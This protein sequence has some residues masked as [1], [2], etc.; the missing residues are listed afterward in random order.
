MRDF[1]KTSFRDHFLQGSFLFGSF[2]ELFKGSFRDFNKGSRR[3][4]FKGSLGNS[5]RGSLGAPLSFWGYL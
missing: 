4:S 3:D 5:L 1:F 2:R